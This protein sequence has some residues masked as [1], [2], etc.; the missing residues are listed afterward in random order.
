MT[1]ENILVETHGKV[2]L[3]LDPQGLGHL[4]RRGT[5]DDVDA[6]PFGADA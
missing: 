3:I 2:G 6:V 1:F 5:Q 4:A